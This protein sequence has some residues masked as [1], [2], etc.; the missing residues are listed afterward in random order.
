MLTD[1]KKLVITPQTPSISTSELEIDL[2][3]KVK[4]FVIAVPQLH[5][6]LA[7][8]R[9]DLLRRVYELCRAEVTSPVMSIIANTINED[10]TAMK[11]PLDMR[12]QR[13]Y[14]VKASVRT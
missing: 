5:E 12:N 1:S 11:A 13:T 10:V 2:V 14:A 9:T 3:L 6:A 8:A 4:A 7:T